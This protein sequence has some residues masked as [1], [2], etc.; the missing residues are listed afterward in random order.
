MQRQ[1]DEIDQLK[2]A[3]RDREEKLR[4]NAENSDEAQK[5]RTTEKQQARALLEVPLPLC[6][7]FASADELPPVESDGTT[8]LL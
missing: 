5:K 2:H 3:L 6:V 4:I 1:A 7:L 8:R